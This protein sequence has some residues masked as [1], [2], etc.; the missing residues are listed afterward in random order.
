MEPFYT[1]FG[2]GDGDGNDDSGH[3]VVMLPPQMV[4]DLTTATSD[5]NMAKA[6]DDGDSSATSTTVE[7][8]PLSEANNFTMTPSTIL[9]LTRNNSSVSVSSGEDCGTTADNDDDRNEVTTMKER[10]Q[11]KRTLDK[12]QH[13]DGRLR[14]CRQLSNP[15]TCQEKSFRHLMNNR[16][17][18]RHDHVESAH[19]RKAT[20]NSEEN[21]VS[22]KTRRTR[23]EPL[24]PP[25]QYQKRRSL[26]PNRNEEQ[27]PGAYPSDLQTRA[28]DQDR[29]RD[30]IPGKRNGAAGDGNDH[31][32]SD[33]HHL[34]EGTEKEFRVLG[35]RR[36]NLYRQE[37]RRCI[38]VS[39][40][41]SSTPDACSR[42]LAVPPRRHSFDTSRSSLCMEA[43]LRQMRYYD[44]NCGTV[45]VTET[46]DVN[47]LSEE[48]RHRK[49]EPFDGRRAKTAINNMSRATK[50]ATKEILFL[51]S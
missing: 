39:G 27:V 31:S 4:L 6:S 48:R 15:T 12:D 35:G 50:Q 28:V 24:C 8:S 40:I 45:S 37:S 7:L 43:C 2:C 13:D 17:L 32:D 34:E 9:Q 36:P 21:A 14:L 38:Y 41:N 44:E 47:G 19:A 20:R 46:L 49:K 10:Q 33:C 5:P 23:E 42:H 29:I 51:F 16:Y 30:D 11:A 1:V 26:L 18:H 3:R 22:Q 25:T